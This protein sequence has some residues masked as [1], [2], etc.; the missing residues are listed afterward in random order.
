M[1]S[2]NRLR[3][4]LIGGVFL[5]VVSMGANIYGE[6]L[7][8]FTEWTHFV[9]TEDLPGFAWGTGGIAVGDFDGDSDLDFALSRREPQT[10]YWFER[11]SDAK[12]TRHTIAKA[13]QLK[14]TLGAAALDLDLDGAVDVA[15][16]G[17]WFKNPGKARLADTAWEAI[18]YDG[19]GHDVIAADINGDEVTDL[20][21]YD[22]HVLCWFDPANHLAKTT[23]LEGREEHGGIA[24]RG[25][26]DL[27]GDG[28]A[29]IVIP[30]VWLE[31]PGRGET[32]WQE[33]VW[34]HLPVEKAS[35]GT[36]M[37]VW[38][39]DVDGDGDNDIVW[40]D[41]DTGFSHVYWVENGGRGERWT[42]HRLPDPPG[43]SRTGSFHSLA[44]VDFDRDGKLEIFSGE[45][46]DPDTYMMSNGLLPMKPKDLKE[47][48]VI[49]ARSGGKGVEFAPVVIHVDNPGWHDVA[50]FD[51]DGDGDVDLVSKVW[52]ADG[53]AYHVDYWRNDIRSAGD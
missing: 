50:A 48:G 16:W 12:W 11:E 3:R 13:D 31:N 38:L 35:Y 25:V 41:C 7:S 52:N 14:R 8:R 26:A 6:D 17:V 1:A 28:H 34:P 39:A 33:H 21:T 2:T 45:Q 4:L 5:T 30:G 20:L 42:R 37:R 24:P 40:S 15:F 36:S 19:G 47:R 53:E 10:A 9:V 49:W 23:I 44:V 29:D 22:G 51:V 27:N 32:K 43:D 18:A 46:E